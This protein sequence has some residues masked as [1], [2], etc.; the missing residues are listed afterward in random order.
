MHRSAQRLRTAIEILRTQGG[1]ALLKKVGHFLQ[2]HMHGLSKKMHK[3]ESHVKR[4]EQWPVDQPLV[5][6]VIP[7]FNY[8]M[9]INGAIQSA[10]NQTFQRFELIIIDD[11]STDECTRGVLDA[12]PASQAKVVHQVNQGLAQTRNNGAALARG[13]YL[14][15]LDADDL[16]EPTYLEKTLTLLE[17][18]ESLGCCYTWVQ[19]FGQMNSV[20]ETRDLDLF[21][22]RQHTTAPSHSVIR[23]E[24]WERVKELNGAGFMSKYD[25]YFEDWV[26]WI[27]M[28]QC[29]YRGQVIEE[30]LI[31]YRVHEASLGARHRQ[32]LH[33][34]LKILREDR[35]D[36]FQDRKYRRRL[37]RNL[38]KRI[39]IENS[40]VNLW[41]RE[42]DQP[43]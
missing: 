39:Y 22:L 38:N 23:K 7:C 12:I 24:A 30:P 2:R 5:S 37:E 41:S 35:R 17:R 4:Q 20:W 15:F 25:G 9:F 1:I 11:G 31:R 10:L 18:D 21:F 13:K 27:D 36:F 42:G 19:C 29:G 3:I 26:F 16:L 14:C 34:M 40:R 32:G 8:G 6:V 33:D 28:V 43:S